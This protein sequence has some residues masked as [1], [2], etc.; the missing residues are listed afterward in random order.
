MRSRHQPATPIEIQGHCHSRFGKLKD[1]FHGNFSERG[2]VGAA[3]SLN[4]DGECVVDLWGGHRDAA[5][6]TAWR[7]DDIVCVQSVSKE[8]VALAVHMLVDRGLLDVDERVTRYWPEY[9]RSGKAETRLR[10][11][12]DHRAGVP[13]VDGASPGMAYAW[14]DMIRGLERTAPLWEPG[15]TP[16]YHSANYG[17]LLGEVVRRVSGKPVGRFLRDEICGPLDVPCFIGLAEEETGRVVQFLN[18]ETHPSAA[19]IREGTNI[20]A[21]SWKIFWTTRTSTA[22]SGCAPKSPR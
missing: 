8:I 7:A 17:F 14:D 4:L 11:L 18:Q 10:W 16:C 21:R 5:R 22:R 13:I 15:T 20:F 1:A 6:A 12:L 3:V 2:E 9:A 19:W